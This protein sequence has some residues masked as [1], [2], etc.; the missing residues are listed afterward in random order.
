MTNLTRFLVI[1]AIV[2]QSRSMSSKAANTPQIARDMN[3]NTNVFHDNK[4]QHSS[5]CEDGKDEADCQNRTGACG[6]GYVTAG[7]SCFLYVS[8]L[9]DVPISWDD[10]LNECQLRGLQLASLNTPAEWDDVTRLLETME[11]DVTLRQIYIGL[12]SVSPS[13]PIM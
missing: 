13:T 11:F 8:A 10:A 9:R 5:A 4:S 7:G 6:P 3:M 12:T 2:L 1:L